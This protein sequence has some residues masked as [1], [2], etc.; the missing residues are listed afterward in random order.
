MIHNTL[1]DVQL[2]TISTIFKA[3][4][5]PTRIKILYLLTHEECNVTAI[6][7]TLELSQSATSHQLSFLKAIKLV[8]SR[9]EG[10]SILYSCD[11]DHV[12]SLLL[13]AIEHSKH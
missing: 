12:I 7:Q 9:R 1:T 11:D 8:K 13:Q 5:D 3:L 2:D 6:A 4:S 10:N